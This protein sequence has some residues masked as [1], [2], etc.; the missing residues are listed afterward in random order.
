MNTQGAESEQRI[1]DYRTPAPGPRRGSRAW[2]V[3]I[4]TIAA[5]LGLLLAWILMASSGPS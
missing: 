3:A 4:L 5:I 2:K 1:L